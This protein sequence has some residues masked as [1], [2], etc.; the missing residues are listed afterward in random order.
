MDF[1][2][3][4]FFSVSYL[5]GVFFQMCLL[6]Y[7]CNELIVESL[8]IPNSIFRSNWYELPQAVQ[9]SLLIVI[10]RTQKP[11]EMKIGK[12]YAMSNDLIV[13]FV[14]AGFTYVLLS[15]LDFQQA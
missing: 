2:I 5:M 11:L 9:R 13:G 8:E 7:N 1:M 3:T 4:L 10:M 14:K 6:Y 15:H 12:L